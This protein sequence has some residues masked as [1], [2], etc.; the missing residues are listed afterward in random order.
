MGWGRMSQF[1]DGGWAGGLRGL[2]VEEVGGTWRG[3]GA[4]FNGWE[5]IWRSR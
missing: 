4:G 5:R 3:E 1:E 2:G